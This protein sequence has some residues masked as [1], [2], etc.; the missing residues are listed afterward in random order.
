MSYSHLNTKQRNIIEVLHKENFSTRHIAK[1][2]GVHHSTVAR[3]LKRIECKYCSALVEEDKKK[4]ASRK[5]RKTKINPEIAHT[6]QTQ[7]Q[8]TWSPEQIAGRIF[9]KEVSTKTIYNWIHKGMIPL[10]KT[11]LR[12]KGKKPKSRETRG[13]FLVGHSIH[14]RN[15]EIETRESFG[16]WEL[17]TM[18]SS[19]GQSKGGFAT[20]VERKTRFYLTIPIQ[21]RSKHS[22]LEAMRKVIATFPK[23][24]FQSVTSDRGKE[25]A[26]YREIEALGIP[27]YFADPYCAWQRG[28]NENSNGLLREFFPKGSDLSQV[29]IEDL[30]KVLLL[31]NHRPR[32]CLGFK[33]PFEMLFDEIS[34]IT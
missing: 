25:F 30:R 34:K 14:E 32:K 11:W 2:I 29:E 24:S 1:I 27:F 16:H 7:L 17:D 18:V 22:M 8:Q 33:T 6:I 4:K 26:C 3:E 19:R 20:F 5:G 12:R 28:S 21:D 15:A 9:P 10:K 23:G 31:L 13:K